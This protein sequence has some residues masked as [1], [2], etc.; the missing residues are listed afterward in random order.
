MLARAGRCCLSLLPMRYHRIRGSSRRLIGFLV[1]NI[2]V[3]RASHVGSGERRLRP[4]SAPACTGGNSTTRRSSGVSHQAVCLLLVT[5]FRGRA[6]RRSGARGITA[7]PARFHMRCR[8][9]NARICTRRRVA[10]GPTSATLCANAQCPSIKVCTVA[11]ISGKD[12]EV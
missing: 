9:M 3:W 4:A 1:S 11:K 10:L 6:A 5:P 2:L 8:A 7:E 12:K